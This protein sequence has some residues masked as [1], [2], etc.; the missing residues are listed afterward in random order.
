MVGRVRR[1]RPPP[2]DEPISALVRAREAPG[3]QVEG[4][5]REPAALGE[6]GLAYGHARPRRRLR[7]RTAFGGELKLI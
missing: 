7:R 1:T 4:R 2:Q 5:R 6:V 3:E